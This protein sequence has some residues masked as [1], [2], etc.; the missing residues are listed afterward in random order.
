MPRAEVRVS[1]SLLLNDMLGLP[2][3]F[4][5]IDVRLGPG[6]C[7][8]L[9]VE[10]PHVREGALMK[11]VYTVYTGLMGSRSVHL[12]EIDGYKGPIEPQFPLPD[13]R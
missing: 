13:V 4:S 8:V 3:H 11:P 7:V 9:E 2:H 10:S 1:D 5:V 6:G 12:M